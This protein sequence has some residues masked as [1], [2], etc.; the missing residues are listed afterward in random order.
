MCCRMRIKIFEFLKMSV[1]PYLLD[2]SSEK[3]ENFKAE[4]N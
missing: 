3:T 4:R 1:S 2:F